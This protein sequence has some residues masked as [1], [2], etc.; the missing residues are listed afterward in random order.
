MYL[1]TAFFIEE[2][3]GGGK[4]YFCPEPKTACCGPD[5][6]FNNV[7]Q[8]DDVEI[9]KD[10]EVTVCN[11]KGAPLKKIIVNGYI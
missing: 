6:T 1:A 8:L 9:R 4:Y 2:G 10:V 5:T 3:R 11:S 7:R